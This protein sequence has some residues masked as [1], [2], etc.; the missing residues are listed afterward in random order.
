MKKYMIMCMAVV[1]LLFASCKNEDISISREVS[2][3]VNPYTVIRDFAKHELNSG[4]LVTPYPGDRVRVNLFIY[5]ADGHLVG[6]EM[7]YFRDYSQTMFTTKELADGNY[8]IVAITSCVESN[9]NE[10][11]IIK[12]TEDITNLQISWNE[13]NDYYFGYFTILGVAQQQ[14]EVS[15]GH[16]SYNI[17]VKPAGSLAINRIRDIHYYNNV[18]YYVMYGNRDDINFSFNSFGDYTCNSLENSYFPQ[19][20]NNTIN[21]NANEFA[22]YSGVARYAFLLPTGRT[23]FRWEALFEDESL[24]TLYGAISDELSL[25][26]QSGKTYEFVFYLSTLDFSVTELGDGMKSE[27]AGDEFIMMRKEKKMCENLNKTLN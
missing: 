18:Y 4:D 16:T 2:F 9:Y 14:I 1:A 11:W 20:L 23:S 7:D 21:P 24:G 25:N 17:D 19:C 10:Y 26:V 15:S 22:N 3:N 5:D 12:G 6:S 13:D 8:T 27:I